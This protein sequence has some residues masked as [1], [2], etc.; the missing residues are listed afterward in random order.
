M[1]DLLAE[2]FWNVLDAPGA[3][4]EFLDALPGYQEARREYEEVAEQIAAKAGFDLYDE[5]QNKLLTY[6]DYEVRAYYGFGLGLRKELIRQML[7]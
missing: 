6:S 5:F 7:L 2:L 1:Q 4:T 3:V